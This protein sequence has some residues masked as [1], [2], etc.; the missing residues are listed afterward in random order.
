[1]ATWTRTLRFVKDTYSEDDYLWDWSDWLDGANI[2]SALVESTDITVDSYDI[3]NLSQ[4]VTC[5]LSAGTLGESGTVSCKVT[6]DDSTP[7]LS[8]RSVEFSVVAL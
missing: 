4:A 6:T 7:R 3:V 1:M 5:R 2:D 8:K